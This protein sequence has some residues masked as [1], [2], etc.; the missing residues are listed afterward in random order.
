M[1]N[2]GVCL[3]LPWHFVSLTKPPKLLLP[4]LPP[5]GSSLP[6]N[7]PKSAEQKPK[8]LAHFQ[9]Q[10]YPEPFHRSGSV[11]EFQFSMVLPSCFLS[12]VTLL[13]NSTSEDLYSRPGSLGSQRRFLF[14]QGDFPTETLPSKIFP[15]KRRINHVQDGSSTRVKFVRGDSNSGGRGGSVCWAALWGSLGLILVFL[16]KTSQNP[17]EIREITP[18]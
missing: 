13:Q 7:R 10:I 15:E 17:N 11:W 2:P 3:F 6:K 12:R 5:A 4:H 8:S 16:Y 18:C 9:P 14:H 1:G